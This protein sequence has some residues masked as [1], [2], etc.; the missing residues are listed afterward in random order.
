MRPADW[1][2]NVFILPAFVFTLPALMKAEATAD[3][4]ALAIATLWTIVAFSLVSS[5]V[6]S[7]NDAIDYERDRKHPVKRRRPIATGDILPPAGFV[8][9]LVL[10]AVGLGVGWRMVN[11]PVGICL[12]SYLVLQVLYNGGLKRLIVV[13]ASILAIGFC[14]RAAAGA[15]AIERPVSVWL[16]GLVFFL[17]L[18]LAFTKRR[19]DLATA[20]AGESNWTSPAGYDDPLELN[21]LLSLSGVTVVLSWILYALSPHAEHMFGVR[22]AGFAILTPLVLIA[23]HRFYR[24]AQRGMSDSPLAAFLEDRVTAICFI[25]FA[26]GMAACLYVPWVADGL[27]RLIFTAATPT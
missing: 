18:Y 8:F 24:R 14:I 15:F 25:L 2:K 1:A 6:Y 3:I 9:G 22:A 26:I 7:I 4:P 27:A 5:G 16:L 19:S 23:V 10:M 20:T 17:T 21:W 12:A 13:D 11:L